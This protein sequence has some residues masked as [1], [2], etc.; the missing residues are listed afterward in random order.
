[1]KNKFC[2]VLT[3]FLFIPLLFLHAQDTEEEEIEEDLGPQIYTSLNPE[4]PLT[5]KP[6][7]ISLIVDYPDPEEVTI[8]APP[9]GNSLTLDRISKTP[10]VTETQTL[11]LVEYRFT[12]IRSGRVVLESFTVVCP[13]GVSETGSFI[14]NIRTEGDGPVVL[15]PRLVWEGA[16]RQMSTGDRVTLILRASGWNSRLPPP[17]FFMTTV[18]HGVILALLPLSEQERAD[19]IAVKI[20]L[21]ALEA[22][23][24]RMET[25]TLR[26]ENIDIHTIFNIPALNIQITGSSILRRTFSPEQIR[27]LFDESSADSP[28]FPEFNYTLAKKGVQEIQRLQCEEIYNAA[29]ELW[30]GGLFAESLALLRRSE[31]DHPAGNLLQTIR[32]QAEE[33][34]GLFNTENESLMRRKLL[35]GVFSFFLFIVIIAPFVCLSIIKKRKPDKGGVLAAFSKKTMLLCAIVFSAALS[36]FFYRLSYSN[37]VFQNKANRFGVTKETPVRRMADIEGEGISNFKEGQPVAVLLN[38]GLWLFVKSNDALGQIG[39]IPAQEVVF[40]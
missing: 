24:F 6:F 31:R 19:G 13:S 25:R 33:S 30:D 11:T 37:F 27:Q 34:L 28:S 14:L 38:S 16:P 18:P 29:K 32:R 35:S 3:V 17:E 4:I 26:H 20:T 9:F 23:Y 8:I 22:G 1:M 2:I 40:Y 7:T 5:G 21:I 12:P 10:K 39:W 36:F 15:S